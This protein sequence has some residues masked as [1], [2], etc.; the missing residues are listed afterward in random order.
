MNHHFFYKAGVIAII[1]DRPRLC[2]ALTLTV[3]VLLAMVPVFAESSQFQEDVARLS[4]GVK[5]VAKP[6]V[7]GPIACVS[8]N[9]F[10]VILGKARGSD[11]AVVAAA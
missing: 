10:P 6:G 7:P 1:R 3:I 4:A 8:E 2:A 11:Q 9:S 5:K